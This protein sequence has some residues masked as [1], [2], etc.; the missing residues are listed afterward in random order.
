MRGCRELAY[1]PDSKSGVCGFESHQPHQNQIIGHCLLIGKLSGAGTSDIKSRLDVSM[2]ERRGSGLQLHVHWFKSSWI[3]Q[4]KAKTY[5]ENAFRIKMFLLR[6]P[7]GPQ[8]LLRY[9]SWQRA[10]LVSAMSPIRIWLGAPMP[11][12]RLGARRL[13]SSL[14]S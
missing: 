9:L 4:M 7:T 14:P 2:T 6:Y 10:R 8:I 1:H 5:K 13:E 3:L 12:L 11:I